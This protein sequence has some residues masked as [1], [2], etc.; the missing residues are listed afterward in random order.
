MG[1]IRPPLLP[2][3]IVEM[4]TA[5]IHLSISLTIGRSFIFDPA[6]SLIC[7]NCVDSRIYV[8]ANAPIEALDYFLSLLSPGGIMIGSF[9]SQLLCV[10]KQTDD[11]CQYNVKHTVIMSVSCASLQSFSIP[12][13]DDA[14]VHGYNSKIPH[15]HVLRPQVWRPI[16]QIHCT[17]SP[18]FRAAT[19]TLLSLSVVLPQAIWMEVGNCWLICWYNVICISVL[20]VLS[21]CSRDWFAIPL[22]EVSNLRQLL[23]KER[24]NKT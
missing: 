11:N 15:S 21:F 23:N 19:L 16:R 17:Y 24:M 8:G 12:F 10:E 7:L 3:S 9:D 20:K 6:I 22:D 1:S 18:A 14:T 13:L 5:S 2:S 4:E